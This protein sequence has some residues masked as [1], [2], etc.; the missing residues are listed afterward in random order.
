[1][2]A[3]WQQ[4]PLRGRDDFGCWVAVATDSRETGCG[5]GPVGRIRRRHGY[6]SIL[7]YKATARA[8]LIACSAGIWP[9]VGMGCDAEFG[10]RC[11]SKSTSDPQDPRLR[12]HSTITI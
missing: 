1:M 3:Y 9:S 2:L 4:F 6:G 12:G 5:S 7:V 8:V 10:H 11:L